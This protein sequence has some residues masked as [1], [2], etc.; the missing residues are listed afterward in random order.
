MPFRLHML[1]LDERLRQHRL[2]LAIAIYLAILAVGSIPG[3]R[4]EIGMLASGIILHSVAYATLTVLLFTGTQGSKSRRAALAGA[5]AAAMGALDET[6]QAALPY[7]V[8]SLGDLLVDTVAATVMACLCCLF[9]P[10]PVAV[11]NPQP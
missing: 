4:Q 6:I 8:G 9:M 5:I 3:A 11:G 2:F 1:L 7:R 10:S